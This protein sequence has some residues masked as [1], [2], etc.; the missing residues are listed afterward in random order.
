MLCVECEGWIRLPFACCVLSAKD[1][2][3]CHSFLLRCTCACL[4]VCVYVYVCVRLLPAFVVC[5]HVYVFVCVRVCVR[6]A[7]SSF[8]CM[9]ACVCVC[10][11]VYVRAFASIV[12]YHT[13]RSVA[14]RTTAC[15][16]ILS[17]VRSWVV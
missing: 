4:C 14:A 1:G 10:V 6:A 2:L 16:H 12:A 5:V 3:G 11:R 8:R 17:S 15:M 7:A 13:T 9:C